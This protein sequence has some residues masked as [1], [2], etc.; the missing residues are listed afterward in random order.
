MS[1][2]AGVSGYLM[3]L[4][5]EGQALA[6]SRD[7]TLSEGQEEIDLTSR[8]SAW[9]KESTPGLRDWS[10]AFNA[11]YIYNDHAQQLLDWHYH[12]RQPAFLTVIITMA[13]GTVQKTGECWLESGD[14]SGP[15][16]GAAERSGTLKGT[17][18]LAIT[19]S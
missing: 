5:I 9:W 4:S 16:S 10:I 3:T 18:A 12:D 1:P 13:D 8:D 19:A 17:H 14:F 2:T 15:Y 7:I 6:E 11:L